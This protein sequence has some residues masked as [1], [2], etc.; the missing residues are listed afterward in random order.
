MIYDVPHDLLY[1]EPNTWYGKPELAD[2]SGLVI[3][4]R[5]KSARVLF[6]YPGSPAAKAG[7]LA[8]DE[9]KDPF[10]AGPRNVFSVRKQR[11]MPCD[12]V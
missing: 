5:G 1:V 6:V 10:A 7:I 2:N 4:S 9:L 8:G 11:K 12:I 3:D